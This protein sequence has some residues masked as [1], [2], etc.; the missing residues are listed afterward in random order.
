MY[1]IFDSC[2]KPLRCFNSWQDALNFKTVCQRYDWTIS[3]VSNRTI[4]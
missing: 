3:R 1:I 2:N 4:L